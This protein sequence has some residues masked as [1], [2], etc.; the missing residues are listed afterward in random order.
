MARQKN[1][2]IPTKRFHKQY[3]CV[4]IRIKSIYKSIRSHGIWCI[5]ATAQAQ[6]HKGIVKNTNAVK[7]QA[8][9]S[10]EKNKR[11]SKKEPR[12]N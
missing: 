5:W 8:S 9:R 1:T 3:S 7:E 4:V 6:Y 10:N 11:I 2:Q 12:N